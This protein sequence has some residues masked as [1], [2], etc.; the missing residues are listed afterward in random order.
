MAR[1]PIDDPVG[2][3]TDDGLNP[4]AE[5]G[6]VL[7]SAGITDTHQVPNPA[8]Y[9]EELADAKLVEAGLGNPVPGVRE[10][11]VEMAGTSPVAE[12]TGSAT[13]VG[14]GGDMV[15]AFGGPPTGD[16]D[17]PDNVDTSE[18]PEGYD[19]E[20]HPVSDFTRNKEEEE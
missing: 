18:V 19:T 6:D 3:P 16:P 4:F 15:A 8:D 10:E 13:P 2:E 17:N 11:E 12:T 9:D 5:G 14:G 1:D 20:Q 7:G